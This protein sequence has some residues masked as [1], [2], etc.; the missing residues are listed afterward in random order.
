ME[1]FTSK[2]LFKDRLQ[3]LKVQNKTIG[4]VAT[5][6]ALHKGHLSL[7]DCAKNGND[8]TAASIFVNPTQF[9]EREDFKKYPRNFDKDL[10]FLSKQGCDIA[11]TPSEEEMYPEPDNR[12]FDFGEL[13]NVMEGAHRPGHFNGV[14]QI[15]SKLLEI[16]Q[17]NKAYFGEKDFQQLAI[18]R[19]LTKQLN[20]NT[21]IVGC[22]I[23][24]ETDGLAMSSR[25]KRLSPD[26]RNNAALISKVLFR[27][28][29]MAGKK[30]VQN[31]KEWMKNQLNKNPYINVE[32]I[33]IANENNLQPIQSWKDAENIRAFAAAWVGNVR[34][35]DN[36]KFYF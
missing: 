33:E 17:P 25:N 20:L 6:G 11:F 5:M 28:K 26:E 19:E 34:L 31:L 23:I 1:T 3:S 16:I 2:N 18:I 35:I 30:S 27:G 10:D 22:P 24:R 21:E 9:N 36:V 12:Q 15:V 4:F 7:I 13:Q 29:E 8:V 32:Y 14:T